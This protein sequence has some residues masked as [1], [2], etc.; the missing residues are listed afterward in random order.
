MAQLT[1]LREL[2]MAVYSNADHAIPCHLSRLAAL[3]GLQ[4]FHLEKRRAY[5]PEVGGQ[6]L[7]WGEGN[8]D[9]G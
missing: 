6:L 5:F 4:R 1:C 9:V 2:R 8:G 3:A 7:F